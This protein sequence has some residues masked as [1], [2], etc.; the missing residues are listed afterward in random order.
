M[1][2]L[3][4]ALTLSLGVVAPALATP[5]Q[6]PQYEGQL[7]VEGDDGPFTGQVDLVFTLYDDPE[8]GF[9]DRQFPPCNGCPPGT[10]IPDGWVYVPAGDFW[11][12]AQYSQSDED[13][14]HPVRLT[15]PF[16]I[17][18]T[19]VTQGRWR[20]LMGNN[21]S[22]FSDCGDDCPVDSVTGFDAA[23]FANALS[24]ANGLSECYGL[25]GCEP[26]GAGNVWCAA[27]ARTESTLLQ[28]CGYHLPTK[29]S[30]SAR[31]GVARSACGCTPAGALRHLEPVVAGA[32]PEAIQDDV[33]ARAGHHLDLHL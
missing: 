31:P 13:K 11:M 26:M 6:I 33:V 20:G 9:A 18:A 24:R 27:A 32:G 17:Q 19:E 21:S 25:T 7:S 28:T 14:M 22:G 23:L 8:D 29:P 3:I 4:V 12:G 5:P 16:L 1:R 15:H 30:G 2:R 10:V